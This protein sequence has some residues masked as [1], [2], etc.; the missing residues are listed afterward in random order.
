MA[1]SGGELEIQVHELRQP[2]HHWSTYLERSS[3]SMDRKVGSSS[4]RIKIHRLGLALGSTRIV[5]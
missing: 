5:A 3:S 1:I 4:L 2:P